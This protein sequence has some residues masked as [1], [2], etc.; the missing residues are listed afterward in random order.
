MKNN[1]KVSGK[2]GTLPV[3]DWGETQVSQTEAIAGCEPLSPDA[4]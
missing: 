4:A 1:A 2:W 3:L